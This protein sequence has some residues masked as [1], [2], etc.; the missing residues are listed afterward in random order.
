VEARHYRCEQAQIASDAP[1]QEPTHQVGDGGLA[2][3]T[4]KI[5]Y[6]MIY[7]IMVI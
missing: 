1:A 2:L 7:N 3:K 4:G 5:I 6:N